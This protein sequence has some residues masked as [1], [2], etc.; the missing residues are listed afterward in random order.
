MDWQHVHHA[1]LVAEAYCCTCTSCFTLQGQGF[2][3][4]QP[5]A[6]A[7][8]SSAPLSSKAVAIEIPSA[9]QS[10]ASVATVSLSIAASLMRQLQLSAGSFTIVFAND[11]AA[12]SA[13]AALQRPAPGTSAAA[14]AAAGVSRVL[15]LRDACRSDGLR[16]VLMLV[17]PKVADV[18]L[19]G[20]AGEGCKT[21][22]FQ[23]R[24]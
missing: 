16:G 1:H 12:A 22:C 24:V 15:G 10:P 2:T 17:E 9:D 6:A 5:T 7:A 4:Q 19:G 23:Q 3:A 11:A 21:S 8:T 18:S 14:A 13:A 20:A